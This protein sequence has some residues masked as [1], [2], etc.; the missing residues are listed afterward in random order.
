MNGSEQRGY[1]RGAADGRLSS[2]CSNNI[3]YFESGDYI[4]LLAE[5]DGTDIVT[6]AYGCYISINNASDTVIRDYSE[7]ENHGANY[8][9]TITSGLG[10][11]A[12][13]FDR[14]T[15]DN[16]SHSDIEYNDEEPHSFSVWVK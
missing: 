9:A 7:N 2:N 4:E 5:S 8:G 1:T 11:S 13:E 14:G 12:Y 10:Q 6:L 3:Y 15:G 16:I